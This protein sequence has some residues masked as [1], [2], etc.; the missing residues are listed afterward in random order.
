MPS[1]NPKDPQKKPQRDFSSLEENIRVKFKNPALLKTAFIHTSYMNE[2]RGE[3][4]E[5][6]E[7]LEFLGDA[8]LEM[9]TTEFLYAAFP[10]T[11][12]GELTSFRSALVKGKHLSDVARELGL[13]EY[14]FLSRGEEKGGGREKSF[15]L[16]NTLEALI[17]AI[18]LDRGFETAHEFIDRFI[19]T[20][21]G[22]ILKKGLH[23]DAKS[24]F[25]E[26]SQEK[27]GMT[28]NYQVLSESGP[29]HNKIF[30]VGA[31]LGETFVAKGTGSS[32]Q[33]AEQDAALAALREKRWS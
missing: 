30:E 22:N 28:P 1:L 10:E 4:Q 33:N 23:V 17:G 20:N 12:E 19:L 2:H 9:V 18:Y 15:L 5:H 16:A 27:L 21:L 25:Q 6:N 32:K 7:R 24:H 31:F 29:D 11:N 14:L 8:V 13:G 26:M 3:V